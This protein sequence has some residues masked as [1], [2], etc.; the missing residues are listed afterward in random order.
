MLQAPLAQP[1]GAH[2]WTPGARHTPSPLQVPAVLSRS[3]EQVG[4]TQIVSALYSAQPPKPSQ[5]PE[6]PHDAAPA[7][8]QTPRGSATPWSMGQ[9]VPSRPT[10]LQ[11]THA[12]WH[13]TLQQTPSEQNPEAQSA[14]FVQ[15]AARGF[16]PQL[17]ATHLMPGAQSESA[18]Q[19]GKHLLVAP[20]QL[21]GAQTVAGPGRQRPAESQTSTSS[22]DAPS[23]TPAL[24]TEPGAYL[25]QAPAPLQVPSSPQVETSAFGH[26]PGVRCAA[27]F[28]TKVHVPGAAC[29]LHALHV[30]PQAV[31]QHTPST[32]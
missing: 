14:P 17:P 1:K 10:W 3:P 18:L 26:M 22:T 30:S 4:A 9:Q 15:T 24:Q 12:P 5:V 32:Q 6:R 11:V 29:V 16:G 8:L 7:S 27:P 21:N 25:R 13:A 19:E 20:S 23:H 2:G 28:A 31:L